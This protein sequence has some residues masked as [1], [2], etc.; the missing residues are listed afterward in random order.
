MARGVEEHV[1]DEVEHI[2]QLQVGL[3][4]GLE[5]VAPRGWSRGHFSWRG[6]PLLTQVL[7]VPQ[8]AATTR[9]NP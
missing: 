1:Q 3:P 2:D 5:M 9:C 4:W 6:G 7:P 8:G